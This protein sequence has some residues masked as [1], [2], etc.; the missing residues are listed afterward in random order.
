M[1][2]ASIAQAESPCHDGFAPS[3][4]YAHQESFKKMKTSSHGQKCMS[5]YIFTRRS[6]TQLRRTLL[7]NRVH[8]LLPRH[9]RKI[10]GN[11]LN[12]KTL[13]GKITHGMNNNRRSIQE[14]NG[15]IESQRKEI[16]HALAG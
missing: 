11:T 14:F 15:I 5:C 4:V 6:E 3:P 10:G 7:E 12:G 13:S 16:D 2:L 1:V 9:L 8:L